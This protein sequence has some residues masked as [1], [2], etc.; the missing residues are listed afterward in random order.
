M[1]ATNDQR[2][3]NIAFKMIIGDILKAKPIYEQ[4]KMIYAEINGK[5]VMRVNI[6]ANCVDKYVSEGE[7]KY[8]SVTIDDASGQ[9]RLKLFADD[10]DMVQEILQGDTLQ[11]VGN[12][13][14]WNEELYLT[15]EVIKRVDPRW[16]LI[17]KLE[18]QQSRQ[19]IPQAE[20]KDNS[21][22]DTIL[23]KIKGAEEEG[24]IDIDNMILGTQAN[25]DAL[26][27]EIKILLEE[28]LIYEPRPGRLRYLG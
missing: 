13:R 21:L 16:L 10:I 9:L 14:I 15:P 11:V 2:K 6:I 12:I 17:R 19:D 25:P 23:E 26:N 18:I 20:A 5:N 22:R 1:E 28:G 24:G 7:K 8:A 4:E 3:R 27:K